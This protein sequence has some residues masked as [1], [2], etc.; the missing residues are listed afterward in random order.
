MKMPAWWQSWHWQQVGLS[1]A[2]VGYLILAFFV[3]PAPYSVF[4]GIAAGACAAQ[5]RATPVIYMLIKAN[6][7]LSAELDQADQIIKGLMQ[8]NANEI[9]RAMNNQL[10]QIREDVPRD[11]PRLN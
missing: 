10:R 6:K 8:T 9:A 5:L 7:N 3:I 11:K 2:M 4:L 1:F